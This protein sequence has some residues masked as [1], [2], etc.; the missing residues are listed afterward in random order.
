MYNNLPDCM[1]R[2]DGEKETTGEAAYIFD[3]GNECV[4]IIIVEIKIT[5]TI[6]D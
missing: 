4:I 6:R 3:T 5:M 1:L 2:L